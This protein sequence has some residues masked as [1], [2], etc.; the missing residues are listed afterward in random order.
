MRIDKNS[1]MLTNLAWV[2]SIVFSLVIRI[3]FLY[4]TS[5][6]WRPIQTE[7]TAYWFVREGI[8]LIN[9]ETPIFGPPWQVPFEFPLFQATAAILFQIGLGSLDVVCRLTA[10][11]YFYLSAFFLYLLCRKVFSDHLTRFL[12]L[13]LYLW[14]PYNIHYSTEPLIDYLSLGLALAF[15]YFILRW[16]DTRSSSW[17]ALFAMICG[18]LGILV[19][20]ATMPVVMIPI[21]VFVVRDILTIYE[22]DFKQPL[23]LQNIL[24]K[25]WAQRSYWFTLVMVVVIPVLIGGL[26]TRHADLIKENSVFTQWLTSKELVNWNF[27]TWA[28]RTDQNTWSAYIAEAER[29]LLPYGLSIFAVLGFF[30]AVDM[31]VFPGERPEARLF[32]VSVLASLGFVLVI[33]LSHYRQ[34]YYYISLSASIAILGGYGLARFWQLSRKK[35]FIFTLVFAIWAIV[36]LA[37]NTK[38]YR[39][40]RNT[41]LAENRKLEKSVARARKVKQYVLLDEWVVV[42]Q[43]DWDPSYIYPLE[44]KA[45]VVTPR[46]LGKPLCSVLADERFALVVVADPA[47]VGNEELLNHT[48]KCFKSHKE[49]LSGVYVVAHE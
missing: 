43:S 40:Y 4:D 46:E 35:P 42:V 47:Y 19:K 12:V 2:I 33:F 36:F 15:L 45:M 9:Y 37:F 21:I 31:I 23:D 17:N 7:M 44:R 25:A 6:Q 28:L 8:D 10:L 34:Q 41:A 27:G 5:Y 24:A 26:W 30:I 11:L 39:A 32:I 16:L 18:S 38:D 13:A 1:L 14:L 20:P 22:K 48:F 29:Y 49:V 3:P